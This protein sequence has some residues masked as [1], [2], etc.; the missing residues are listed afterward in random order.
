MKIIKKAVVYGIRDLATKGR[1]TRRVRDRAV[2]VSKEN[3]SGDT[4]ETN[5]NPHHLNYIMTV[6]FNHSKTV[7]DE[8]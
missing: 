2:H 4:K 1:K 7:G 6:S 5:H 8:Y 3:S